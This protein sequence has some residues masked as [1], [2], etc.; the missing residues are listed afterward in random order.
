MVKKIIFPATS[1]VHVARQQL[2]LNELGKFFQVCIAT[3]GEKSMNMSEVAVDITQKFKKAIDSEKPDIALIRG[4]R[5]EQLPIATLC[6]YS[7]IPIAHIEGFDLSGVIDNKVRYAISHLSDHHFV[8]NE[9]SFS[10][11]KAMGFKNVWNFGSLDVEYALQCPKIDP[12]RTKPYIVVLYHQIPGEDAG[13]V[14]NGIDRFV[15]ET[16]YDVVGIR[17]NSDY[18]ASKGEEYPPEQF[19]NLLRHASIVVGNSSAGIKEATALGCRVVNI[20]SR[21]ANRLKPE[22]VVDCKCDELD[23]YQAIK[24]QM[25]RKF[26]NSTLYYQPNTSK[27]ISLKIREVI[28]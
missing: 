22:N 1:R 21:Q 9:D 23:I 26:L 13:N 6:A 8:T 20:G 27:N 15:H 2:L 10:R 14:K 12:G 3:Y 7:G 4:D 16:P 24:Y 18:T 11:A 5:F 25:G 19:I 28:T 17:G